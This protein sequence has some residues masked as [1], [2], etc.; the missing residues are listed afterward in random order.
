MGSFPPFSY[1]ARS[2]IHF[3][4]RFLSAWQ[5]A[6]SLLLFFC[7]AG[8]FS[9][10]GNI[11]ASFLIEL[12][13]HLIVSQCKIGLLLQIQCS[14][15]GCTQNNGNFL[16]LFAVFVGE[17]SVL[18]FSRWWFDRLLSWPMTRAGIWIP[19]FFLYLFCKIRGSFAILKIQQRNVKGSTG[20]CST[21]RF[22]CND[23]FT[24]IER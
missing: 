24:F 13:T 12:R 10:S 9:G 14:R 21:I 15:N 18:I 22:S 8:F 19:W 16:Q 7:R 23:R 1:H 5:N 17:P 3:G 4:W 20:H 2:A 11:P 6:L